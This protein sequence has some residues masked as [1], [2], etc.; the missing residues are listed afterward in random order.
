[1]SLKLILIA[2]V[3]IVWCGGCSEEDVDTTYRLCAEELLVEVTNP[4]EGNGNMSEKF[5]KFLEENEYLVEF[6]VSGE[7]RKENNDKA[8]AR[9]EEKY[10]S[11]QLIDLAKVLSLVEN[12]TATVSFSYVLSRGDEQVGDPKEVRLTA[13]VPEKQ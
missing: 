9:F 7:S 8:V 4:N 13:S 11:L 1:M 10:K 2:L 6:E 3:A 12:Q 5:Y